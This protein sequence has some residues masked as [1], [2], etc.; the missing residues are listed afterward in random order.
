MRLFFVYQIL[1]VFIHSN[2]IEDVVNVV[3]SLDGSTSITVNGTSGDIV[4][5]SSIEHSPILLAPGSGSFIGYGLSSGGSNTVYPNVIIATCDATS[6]SQQFN[7]TEE[8]RLITVDG[9]HCLDVWNCG[10]ANGTVMDLYP[11]FYGPTCGDS[12]RT[13][14]ELFF[15]DGVTGELSSLLGPKNRLCVEVFGEGGPQVDLWQCHGGSNQKWSYDASSKLLSSVGYAGM[16]LS[17][18][19]SPPPP[20]PPPPPCTWLGVAS[21]SGGGTSGAPILVQRNASCLG[22]AATVLVAD[23][24][25]PLNTSV[26][27]VSTYTVLAASGAALPAF[28]LPLG[29]SLRPVLNDTTAPLALWT[30]WTRGCVDNGGDKLGQPGMCFAEGAWREPFSSVPLPTAPTLFRLGNRD[31]GP[32]LAQF[33]TRIDD[34]ITVPLVTLLRGEDDFGFTLLLSP[35]EPLLELLLRTENNVIDF[36]RLL[37]RLSASQPVSVTAHFRA[38]AADWRPPLQTVL[39]LFPSYVL[40]HAMNTSDF[41]GL[42][43]YSWQAP[44]NK[45]YADSVGFRTNWELS[46]TFMPYDGLDKPHYS[47]NCSD[48]QHLFLS[49]TLT[50]IHFS[51]TLKPFCPLPGRMAQPWANQCRAPSV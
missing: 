32:T 3:T 33:G 24:Y 4:G 50:H 6:A 22:G 21:V 46:G 19:P 39:D 28:T 17:A 5:V 23:S 7:F 14:N 29:A 43:G 27:W 48:S 41:D 16:C 40:P 35:A 51:H 18:P 37:R 26:L 30:T 9:S 12:S 11:C 38:H 15:F 25:A 10:M 8:G 1:L 20:P 42:G 2:A 13:I 49:H 34:S 31:F 47:N 45:S 44:I 36:A